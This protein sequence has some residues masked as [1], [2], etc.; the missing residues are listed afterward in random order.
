L[1]FKQSGESW[2]TKLALAQKGLYL[3][4][5]A[6]KLGIQKQLYE[7]KLQTFYKMDFCFVS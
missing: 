1:F 4:Q 3:E 2:Q 7:P 5:K 6:V